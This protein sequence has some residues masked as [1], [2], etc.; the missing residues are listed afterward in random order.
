MINN[1]Y[2]FLSLALSGIA[3]GWISFGDEKPLSPLTEPTPWKHGAEKSP[4]VKW[5]VSPDGIMYDLVTEDKKHVLFFNY[6]FSGMN[7]L[8]W[9][10][11]DHIDVPR[12][13]FSTR[14]IPPRNVEYK[15]IIHAKTRQ[16]FE[17]LRVPE[18]ELYQYMLQE[19]LQI[20]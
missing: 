17:A 18:K 20:I 19:C 11:G 6:S 2:I 15:M 12:V 4:I 8:M 10:I 14:L 13:S 1:A 16:Q 3:L 7:T 5:A 9:D